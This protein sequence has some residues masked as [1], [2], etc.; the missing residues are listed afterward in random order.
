MSFHLETKLKK[1]KMVIIDVDGVLTD[2][3]ITYTSDGEEVKT[4][5]VLDGTGIK[6]ARRL[7]YIVVFLTGRE[8]PVVAQRAKELGVEEVHQK[9][10]EKKKVYAQLLKKYH[11]KDEE[12]CSIGDDILDLGILKRAG[13][14]VAV[15]NAVDE[16]K[17]VAH[18]VTQRRGG[19]GAV[20]EVLDQILQAQGKWTELVS[21]YE[22]D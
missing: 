5:N 15:P 2:G 20:R 4:F 21:A 22:K 7:G 19:E 10:W 8:S 12:V 6:F 14:A 1:I 13:L 11:L 9:I 16:V 17:E 18:L 3:S